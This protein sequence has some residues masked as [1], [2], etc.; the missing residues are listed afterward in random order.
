MEKDILAEF[1]GEIRDLFS[2]CKNDAEVSVIKHTIENLSIL[3]HQQLH[4]ALRALAKHARTIASDSDNLAIVATAYGSD[5]DGSQLVVQMLKP[6][7]RKIPNLRIFN[8]VPAYVK[9]L[10]EYPRFILVDDFSGT[11]KTILNRLKYL[12]E[13]AKSRSVPVDPSVYLV[14]CME[15]AQ[16]NI[17]DA[18]YLVNVFNELKAGISGHFEGIELEEKVASMKRLEEELAAAIGATPLPSFGH[19]SAEALYFVH[20][21]NA[22]NSNFPVFGGLKMPEITKELQS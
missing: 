18:G 9:K 7:L 13:N 20:P 17:R 2:L 8:S 5:P 4:Q 19:G 14:S 11:G 6:L 3:R 12:T 1:E 10:P 15:S 21:G 22:P 16:R